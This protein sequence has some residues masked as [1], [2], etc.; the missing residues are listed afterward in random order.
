[1]ARPIESPEL[2]YLD[3]AIIARIGSM[4]LK[5]RTVVEGFLAGLHRSPYK[6]FSI[7]FAEYRQYMPGDDLSTIDWKI[8]ARSDRYYVKKYEQET[9]L[10]CH[11]LLDVSASMGYGS[12]GVSKLE[13]GS[14]LAASL[15]YLI[16]KQRDA[17][18]LMAFD[19]SIVSMLPA[20]SRPG[21]LRAMLGS[22][23][24][25]KLGRRSDVSKPL[26]LLA[27]M[28]VKR[29]MVVLVSDL[30]DEP[31]RVITGLK[32][33]RFKGS[34]VVVFHVLDTAELTFPFEQA[35]RFTDLE[36]DD[37]V[38]AVPALVREQY[39]TEIR[40]L[41]ARYERELRQAGIDYQLLETTQP[42]DFALMA[43][44]STRSRMF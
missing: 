2:R 3:P 10:K 20:S 31:E 8:Y 32:H 14:Y 9:N 18:G 12:G 38:M 27:E 39:L 34:D 40:D 29:G 42:L 1:M 28:L 7:E 15:A 17:V 35:T 36:T 19:E 25:L 22:L 21:H 4:E 24:Q 37:E 33:L 26:H 11:L 5:A 41:I 13:Y 23:A 30:L 16:T 6:G 44:L 43:Y